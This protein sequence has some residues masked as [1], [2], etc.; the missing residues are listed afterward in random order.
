MELLIEHR[1]VPIVFTA[2]FNLFFGLLIFRLRHQSEKLP[3]TYSQRWGLTLMGWL[4]FL[5]GIILAIQS[6]IYPLG[7]DIHSQFYSIVSE[8]SMGM[9]LMTYVPLFIFGL[10]FPRPVTK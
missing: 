4:Y 9:N 1:F 6:I 3:L 8:F 5:N 10:T 2:I 7:V